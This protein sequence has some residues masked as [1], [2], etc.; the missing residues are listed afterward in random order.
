MNEYSADESEAGMR[1]IWVIKIII[2]YGFLSIGTAYAAETLVAVAANFAKPMKELIAKFEVDSP[3]KVKMV[4]GSSGKIYAQIINGAPFDA[5]FSADQVK[6]A[7]LVKDELALEDSRYT[8]ATGR[9]VIWSPNRQKR[10]EKAVK[11]V[12]PLIA[13]ANP[14]T[15][16]YGAA[17]LEAFTHI[18]LLPWREDRLVYGENIAQTYQFIASGAAEFGAVALSQV[19]NEPTASYDIVPDEMYSPIKQDM[20]MLKHA[21]TNPATAD[22]LNFMRSEKVADMIKTFGYK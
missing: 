10:R 2:L 17:A 3:H 8:Y 13:I 4:I 7:K 18:S 20:V 14:K 5:F 9:L 22:F 11:G 12:P 1:Q 6:P 15:A 16:P 21:E 19:V